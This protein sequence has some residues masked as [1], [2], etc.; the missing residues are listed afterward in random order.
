MTPP[1]RLIATRK[2]HQKAEDT[3]IVQLL[4]SLDELD[5]IKPLDEALFPSG[6][7]WIS[8]GYDS[9]EQDFQEGEPFI[10][11]F[12]GKIE[13]EKEGINTHN[14]IAEHWSLGR[15]AI[16]L[17]PEKLIPIIKSE[18]PDRSTGLLKY[19][20]QSIPNNQFYI[21]NDSFLYGPFTAA[22]TDDEMYV[23][24]SQCL[25]LALNT[26]FV[27]KIPLNDLKQN[28]IYIAVADDADFPYEAFISSHKDIGSKL[29]K[30][31]EQIDYINDSQLVTFFSKY[32]YGTSTGKL[33]R[34]SAEQLK[35][36]ISQEAKKNY[37]LSDDER[38]NRIKTVLDNYLSADEIG[39][40]V[41]DGWLSSSEGKTFL[42]N[43][44][45][46]N[47]DKFESHTSTFRT[48]KDQFEEQISNLKLEK[49]ELEKEIVSIKS[50]V[51][52]EKEDANREI[53]K[54]HQQTQEQIESERKKFIA[55]LEQSIFEKESDL[56]SLGEQIDSESAKLKNI[57]TINDLESEKE[58]LER[59][60]NELLD[61]VKEQ[62]KLLNSPD[63][64]REV[65]KQNTIL[66]LLQGR[67]FSRQ[68]ENLTYIPPTFHEQSID[69]GESLVQYFVNYFDDG[70]RSFSYEE[71]ANL[72]ITI[73][74]S[75]MVVLKGLPGAGKTS[76][77]IRLAES[78]WLNN[79][80][81]QFDN[82]L[83]IPVSRG[84]VSGRD[85]IGFY[86]ALKGNY[87]PAKTGLF[88]FLAQGEL[89][90]AQK[91]MR[92]VLLD[93]A[94]LS[95]IEHYMSDFLGLFDSEGRNRPIDTG[96]TKANKRY[97]HVPKNL[98]F[99][100][101][102]NNDAT[103]EM[104][105]PRLCDRVPIISMDLR[106]YQSTRS[107]DACEIRGSIK[108]TQLENYFGKVLSDDGLE[109]LPAKIQQLIN[110]FE[111]TN[112]EFGQNIRVSKRK[113]NAMQSY[114]KRAS[115]YM[116]ET[117][118]ADFAVSQYMLPSINGFGPDFKKRIDKILDQSQRSGL[119]RTSEIVNSI[120]VTGDA[121]VGS[122]S[123][124]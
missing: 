64:A 41:I 116:D 67:D 104:L 114:F 74:Q 45:I 111:D 88:Q 18:L 92:L 28:N 77:A 23:T 37:K 66:G 101:T 44:I 52:R 95:P 4:C 102:I 60:K 10:L 27:A 9:I 108:Y 25:P 16:K 6:L 61:A 96:N 17:D 83:N 26:N 59:R 36:A 56:Q 103:T 47:P 55:D 84:W 15:H 57:N 32:K 21:E 90:D 91:A 75:F 70:G 29:G 49:T 13:K 5:N 46:E 89:K 112:K 121:H 79:N 30:N 122:F 43:L 119:N 14:D 11:D 2:Y 58:Y 39:K 7:V 94:N 124:F 22:P 34:K 98:R 110:I 40:E 78:L 107:L 113:I 105:S 20:Q 115:E 117:T 120:L 81:N 33:S 71:M 19:T 31:I 24:P 100:A 99:I 68:N 35:Q 3:G 12:Y 48:Q 69:D 38:L 62:E 8:K 118:A 42:R 50:K 97:L 51:D 109:D 1:L 93:E 85:F 82:F 65:V 106:D 80:S 87:Q 63:I 54:I 76:T 53:Q 73:Q 86:N 123:Y 72:L